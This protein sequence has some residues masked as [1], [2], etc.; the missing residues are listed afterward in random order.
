MKVAS[1]SGAFEADEFATFSLLVNL[2]E[3][4][5]HGCSL[6]KSGATCVVTVEASVT[7]EGAVFDV[8]AGGFSIEDEVREIAFG[9]Y[10]APRGVDRSHLGLFV[11]HK[12]TLSQGGTLSAESV[13]SEATRFT[14]RLP[15]DV[16]ETKSGETNEKGL[17]DEWEGRK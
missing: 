8:T 3:Y 9:P 16:P 17:A 10:Y 1:A 5:L 12:L 11:A 14:V 6:N 15:V 13:S 7:G 2:V 4:A